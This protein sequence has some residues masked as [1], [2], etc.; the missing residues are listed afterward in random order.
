M[1]P[2]IL[3]N[4]YT[5]LDCCQRPPFHFPQRGI[6]SDFLVMLLDSLN[7]CNSL[8]LQQISKVEFNNKV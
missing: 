3:R 8:G 7:G 4:F 1:A 5:K 2:M 6:L